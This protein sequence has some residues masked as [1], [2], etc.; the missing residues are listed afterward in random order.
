[1]IGFVMAAPAVAAAVILV[2]LALKVAD[3]S[4]TACVCLVVFSFFVLGVIINASIVEDEK[5]PC[6]RYETRMMY[7]AATKT[8]MP[9]RVCV[10]RGEWIEETSD[11][12]Q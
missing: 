3:G 6:H 4:T 8:T 1:M 5:G 2:W 10:L 12:N 9:Y 11:D 7:N